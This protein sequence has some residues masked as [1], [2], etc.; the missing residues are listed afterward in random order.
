VIAVAPLAAGP[1]PAEPPGAVARHVIIVS[2]DGLRPDAIPRSRRRYCT[3][4]A[5]GRVGADG[6]DD[7]PSK[8]LP[9][10]TSMLTGCCRSSHGITWNTDQTGLR[11]SCRSRPSS[12]W[13]QPTGCTAAFFSKAKLRHLQ[14]PGSLDHAQAP[15][16]RTMAGDGDGGRRSALHALP[17][18]EPDVRP[19]CGAGCR[20]P[21]LRLDG[22]RVR[23]RCGA[24]TQRRWLLVAADAGLRRVAATR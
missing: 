7:H 18:P 13:R 1:S 2:I 24:P 10:H 22:R 23:R 6:G 5:A 4:D 20:R 15:R 3:P 12:R 11:G 21:Q 9:S 16:G 17:S 14:K 19:H 8:T